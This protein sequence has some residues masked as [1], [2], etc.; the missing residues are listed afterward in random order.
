MKPTE[1]LPEEAL[2][3]D[4]RPHQGD[5]PLGALPRRAATSTTRAPRRG[6][7]TRSTA[8]RRDRSRRPR[9]SSSTSTSWRKGE[10][11]MA[12]GAA[13]SATT[14]AS[15]PTR[16]TTRASASTRSTSRICRRARLLA[17]TVERVSSVAWAADNKTLFYATTD[18][19]KRPYRLY[20]HTLGT[21]PSTDALAL[22]GEGRDAS[23]S[24]SAARAAATISSSPVGQ[25]HD[26]RSGATS[27][28]PTRRASCG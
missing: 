26:R 8:A 2:R 3:R 17:E 7:S 19:A 1:A 28:R 14:G 6:S 10:Q 24:A 4:A 20:R 13:P 18:P 22:R 5:G 23:A 27:R 21:D 12:V 25:P 15:S 9:R 11:F 16:P